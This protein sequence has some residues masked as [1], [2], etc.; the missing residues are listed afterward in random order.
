MNKSEEKGFEKPVYKE[1]QRKW[2]VFEVKMWQSECHSVTPH[3][4]QFHGL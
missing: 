3:H 4:W 1:E 2:A